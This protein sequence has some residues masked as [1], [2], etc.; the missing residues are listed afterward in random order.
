MATRSSGNIPIYAEDDDDGSEH[1]I[2]CTSEKCVAAAKVWIPK[3][4]PRG[5][6]KRPFLCGYCCHERLT[7]IE[8]EIRKKPESKPSSVTDA[9]IQ[10]KPSYSEILR[11]IDAEKREQ[12]KRT[13]NILISGTKPEKNDNEKM[14]IYQIGTIAQCTA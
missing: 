12:D 10:S 7:E 1:L 2:D 13:K 9:S 3:R 14:L 6:L 11:N 5:F 8:T 4:I